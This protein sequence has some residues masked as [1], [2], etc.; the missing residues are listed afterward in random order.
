MNTRGSIQSIQSHITSEFDTLEY[1]LVHRPGR[2]IDRLTPGNK[3]RL[4]FEDI[5]FHKKMMSEH[6]AFTASLRAQGVNVV[7]LEDLVADIAQDPAVLKNM[8][9]EASLA[10][11][12]PGISEVL[13][14]HCSADQLIDILFAGLTA[15][16]FDACTKGQPV[17]ASQEDFF[18]LDPIPN[19]YFS[20]DPA[21]VINNGVV[22]CKAH[23]PARVRDM[24]LTRAV[25]RWHPLLKQNPIVYGDSP[26]ED[27]PYTIEGG[28]III[29]NE[30]AIA[31]GCSQ[32]TRSESIALLAKNLFTCGSTRRVYEV[33]IPAA[34]EYMHLDT[35]FTIVAPG[36]VV[37]Y[38]DVIDNITEIRRF[39]AQPGSDGVITAQPQREQ[40]T[41]KQILV[42]EFNAPLQVINTANNDA[43]YAAREQGSDGTNTLAIA[44]GR[45][46]AYD[47][48]I[49]TNQALRAYGIGVIEIEGSELVRGLGGPRCMTMPLRR[50]PAKNS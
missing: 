5:P 7:Y 26:S 3:T 36:I 34:R 4:L 50:N 33:N 13:L 1:V 45:V 18:I 15:S 40:R 16:E 41:F 35:V 8:V 38:S 42:D 46:V 24:L 43:R 23:Y 28:D 14:D 12:Q 6:D 29:I 11:G 21:A 10:A 20:R 49:H 25:L 32:R 31:I 48:N 47:R 44:P 2:E 27:R 37:S 9:H 22:S 39:E 17:S 19:I 30:E